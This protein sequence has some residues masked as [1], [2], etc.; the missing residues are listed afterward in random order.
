MFLLTDFFGLDQSSHTLQRALELK[1]NDIQDICNLPL[2][3]TAVNLGE[4]CVFMIDEGWKVRKTLQFSKIKGKSV[5][6]RQY[7]CSSAEIRDDIG[8]LC[9]WFGNVQGCSENL[10]QISD[11]QNTAHSFIP[12]SSYLCTITSNCMLSS[13]QEDSRENS[14]IMP[15]L[16]CQKEMSTMKYLELTEDCKKF[17]SD[18]ISLEQHQVSENEIWVKI[19]HTH[20]YQSDKATHLDKAECLND[21]HMA[22]AQ[23]LLRQA[24]PALSGLESTLRQQ[25]GLNH[26]HRIA[27][28]FY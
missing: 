18:L 3:N 19:H 10:F 27:F 2:V 25:T 12:L 22:C 7:K 16:P 4:I 15:V 13:S 14:G 20:L 28:K 21:N 9:S 5:S 17:I 23:L 24:F 26:F 6:G 8:V 1:K 11:C